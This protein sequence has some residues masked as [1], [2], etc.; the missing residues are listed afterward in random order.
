MVFTMH[1]PP[2]HEQ[3]S[4]RKL[5]GVMLINVAGFLIELVGGLAFG[6]VALMSDAVHM[7]FDALAYGSAFVAAYVAETQDISD[8]LT[9]GLHRV[10]TF[11][12]IFNGVLLIPMAGYIIWHAYSRFLSPVEVMVGPTIA[13]AVFGLLVNLFSVWWIHDESMSLNERGAF[14]HLLGDAGGSIAVI[15]GTAAIA[16]TGIRV[17]DPLVAALIAII[18]LTSAARVLVEGTGILLQRSAI[19]PEDI[20]DVVLSIEGVEEVDD[21]RSWQVCSTVDVCTLHVNLSVR[22]FE[23]AEEVRG[24]LEDVLRDELGIDHLTI[25]VDSYIEQP[26]GGTA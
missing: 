16:V 5:A 19:D 21:I 17:I 12:A 24:R 23:D 13:V 22:T 25:Q 10:E 11:T 18:V 14:Y 8:R 7:L 3:G 6:S 26:D 9:F 15:V 20:R 4:H 1:E 2:E